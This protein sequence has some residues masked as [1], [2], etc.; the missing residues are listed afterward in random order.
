MK[1]DNIF[2]K[3]WS[4]WS[5]LEIFLAPFISFGSKPNH[6]PFIPARRFK[7]FKYLKSSISSS[8]FF[9]S[10]INYST[11]RRHQNPSQRQQVQKKHASIN[12]GNNSDI[13]SIFQIR[14]HKIKRPKNEHSDEKPYQI[15]AIFIVSLNGMG[16]KKHL[17]IKQI[18]IRLKSSQ[19]KPIS[20]IQL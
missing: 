9:L 19:S 18:K 20:T 13:L 3:G 15:A 7:H 8:C 14:C 4:I 1:I 10:Y 17:K 12:F 2:N 16:P 6:H 11:T 5:K